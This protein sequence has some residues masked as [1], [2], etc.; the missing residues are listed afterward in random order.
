MHGRDSITT[1]FTHPIHTCDTPHCFSTPGVEAHHPVR[2]SAP[3]ERI[4]RHVWQGDEC[5]GDH[6]CPGGVKLVIPKLAP[7]TLNAGRGEGA[8]RRVRWRSRVPRRG[9]TG[10]PEACATHPECR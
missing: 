7:H 8:G 4:D 3:D 9:K 5:G 2:Q 6:V 1:V 10:Y